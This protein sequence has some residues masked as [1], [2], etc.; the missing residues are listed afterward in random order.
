MR[1][2]AFYFPADY[3]INM[4]ELAKALE[5]RGFDSLFVP[6]HTHIPASRKSPFPGG[7]EL[8]KRYSHTHDP[9]VALSFAAAATK[10][11][12]LGT[13]ILLVPQHEPIV[14]AKAIASLDQLSGG[15]FILGI[16]GGWNV[17][18]M[19]NHGAKYQTRFKQMREHVL[20]MKELWT[21][22]EASY[23]GEF[24][25]F[26]RVWSWPK[27]AQK[28]HPPV[29]LGGETDH[30]LRRV[31][32]YCDG[33]FPRPRGGFDVVKGVAHLHQMAEKAGRDPS[34]ITTIVFGAANDAKAL[35]SYDKAGIQSALLA[36]PDES[37]DEILRYLDKIAPL[38]KLP[39]AA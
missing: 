10:K 8:P 28:P 22:D 12:K 9:F 11:L 21:K 24:V 17:E 16:G 4:A 26:D 2:G 39:L 37:R 20:A 35:E 5:D 23:N 19:E 38:A 13:G 3:G 27:P 29:I 32:E 34:T 30:T 25:K 18:E 14:T 36:I 33:W 6:E 15:R 1:V 31:I 7:G